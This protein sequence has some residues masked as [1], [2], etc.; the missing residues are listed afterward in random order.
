MSVLDALTILGAGA[1]RGYRSG[2]N[3]QREL[4]EARR[5]ALLEDREQATRESLARSQMALESSQAGS[6]EAARQKTLA[7][8]EDTRAGILRSQQPITPG[9]VPFHI[10]LP[11]MGNKGLDIPGTMGSIENAPT[12]NLIQQLLQGGTSENVARINQAGETG[13]T[14][15][16]LNFRENHPE[17]YGGHGRT[18]KT[19]EERKMDYL[20][21]A[22]ANIPLPI[23]VVTAED[24]QAYLAAMGSAKLEQFKKEDPEAFGIKPETKGTKKKDSLGIRQ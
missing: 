23:S 17:S 16:E 10:N 13:R 21:R 11:G 5:K 15:Q 9:G 12:S 1:A 24:A 4:A 6:A 19:P 7:D 8:T 22:Y 3:I 20:D 18:P 2:Q 14:R